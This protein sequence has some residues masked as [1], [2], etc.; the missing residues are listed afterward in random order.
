MRKLNFVDWWIRRIMQCVRSISFLVL[1][2]GFLGEYFRPHRGLRQGDPLSPYL[3]V[4]CEEGLSSMIYQA[5][6]AQM[7]RRI[8]ITRAAPMVSHL[9][10]AD[11]SIIFSRASEDEC[12]TIINILNTYERATGQKANFEKSS[13]FFSPNVNENLRSTIWSETHFPTIAFLEKYLGLPTMIGRSKNGAMQS[14][15]D[16]VLKRVKG[17]KEKLLSTGG[18]EVLIKAVAQAIPIYIISCF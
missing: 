13:I 14:L 8:R 17:W 16:R 6:Q 11:D 3:F 9:F 18:K 1:I 15:K 7:L 12:S 10:F 4:L 5:K 2:N